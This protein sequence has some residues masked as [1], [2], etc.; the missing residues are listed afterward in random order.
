MRDTVIPRLGVSLYQT[1]RYARAGGVCALGVAALLLAP[2]C[3]A[4]ATNAE[5]EAI[6]PTADVALDGHVL[7]RVRGISAF[8][9]ET[10]AQAIADRVETVAADAI[11][12][13]DSLQT[14]DS[15]DRSSIMA[16]DS[17]L[18][19]VFDADASLEGVGRP[20]VAELY[21][22][23]I[24]EAIT[25]YRRDRSSAAL[26]RA[27]SRASVATLLLLI[28]LFVVVWT[29]RRLRAWAERSLQSKVEALWGP[30]LKFL[31]SDRLWPSL[32]AALR[33]VRTMVVLLL[34]YVYADYILNLY[35]WT[36]P[37]GNRL[38]EILI[39]PPRTL[40]TAF[41]EALP[42]LVFVAILAVVVRYGIKLLRLFFESIDNHTLVFD[43]FDPD[44]AMPTYRLVR[45]LVIAFALVVAYPYL[46][47]SDTDAFKGISLFIGVIFSL[48]S[49]SAIAN[50]I[51]GYSL[52]YRRAFKIGDRVRIGDAYGD[53]A[54]I[55]LQVTHVRTI[56]NEEVIIPNSEILNS[57]VINYSSLARQRGL[58][59]HT[60]V[61]IGY[62]VPWRQVEA[63]LLMAAKNTTELQLEP[64]PFVYQR[65]LRDFS[66]QYELNVYT[67]QPQ[68]A[69]RLYTMLHR[70]I[71]DVFNEHGVQIMTPSYESDP[72]D[73]KVVPKEKWFLS[74]ASPSAPTAEI[75]SAQVT[76]TV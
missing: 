20:A 14:V 42:N 24:A 12:S 30:S 62:E 63:M 32:Y 39:N 34:T 29:S 59:L 57:Q 9:A 58:I 56:K 66:V 7:F 6:Q 64:A 47:G 45:T 21:K 36:R 31:P 25:A 33:V 1:A 40:G 76:T 35:P 4:Q 19:S 43:R 68:A 23:R 10:R 55:R 75:R 71:L 37:L 54:E 41:L 22:R 16:G 69:A 60:E 48:G 38:L 2:Q 27:T 15:T 17:L 51:A 52:T 67:D 74:P 53:V 73:P 28:A 5:E 26:V 13:P 72:E 3:R 11:I 8:P 61:G 70:N 18:M 50:V 44:W 46:P 49:T 65:S